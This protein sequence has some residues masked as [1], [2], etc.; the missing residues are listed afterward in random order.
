MAAKTFPAHTGLGSDNFA[1]RALERLSDESLQALATILNRAEQSGEWCKA[2]QLVLIVLLPKPDGDRRPIGLLPMP[3]RVWMRARINVAREWERA[4]H[5]HNVYAGPAMGAQRAAWQTSFQAE[6]SALSKL[7]YAQTNLDIV[8]AFE[9]VKHHLVV[10]AARKHGYNL[11]VL[12]LSLAAYRAPRAI[13][14]NGVYSR[15]IIATTG[16]TAGSGFATSELRVLLLDLVDDSYVM[17]R[18]IR[19]QC[20]YYVDDVTIEAFG[21]TG[22]VHLKSSAASTYVITYFQVK[23]ELEVSAKKSGL[24]TAKPTLAQKVIGM[25]S[26]G[27]LQKLKLGKVL[28]VVGSGGAKRCIEGQKTRLKTAAEKIDRVHTMRKAGVCTTHIVKATF[29]AIMTYDACCNGVADGMLR[30]M[31]TTTARGLAPPTRGKNSELVLYVADAAGGRADPAFEAHGQPIKFWALSWW[32]QWR[33]HAELE[34]AHEQAVAKLTSARGSIWRVV[35]GPATAVVATAW[36]IGWRFLNAVEVITESGRKL[37]FL[38][39]SPEAIV[40]AVYTSVRRWRLGRI[41]S[42]MPALRPKH[43]AHARPKTGDSTLPPRGY[44]VSCWV[45]PDWNDCPWIIGRLL[46]GRTCAVK[47]MPMW[48]RTCRASLTSTI[49]GGQWTQSRLF[50]TKKQWVSDN[51][52]RLCGAVEGTLGH[53]RNCTTTKPPAGWPEQPPEVLALV[54]KLPRPAQRM[55]LDRGLLIIRAAIPSSNPPEAIHWQKWFEDGSREG[56][57]TWYVDGSLLDGPRALTAAQGA[58][59]AAVGPRGELWAY[60]H[61]APPPWAR[62]IP[63]VEAWAFSV[64]LHNTMARRAVIT[65]CLGNVKILERGAELATDARR[66]MARLWGPI[67]QAMDGCADDGQLTWMPAHTSVADVGRRIRS[68]GIAITPV[69][70]RAN[71]LVDGLAKLAAEAR[72]VPE[73]ARKFIAQAEA[74]V[75]HSAAMIGVTCKAANNHKVT[76]V[77]AD[78]TSTTKVL[79]DAQPLLLVARAAAKKETRARRKAQVEEAAAAKAAKDE[80]AK[81]ARALARAKK[82]EAEEKALD[83]HRSKAAKMFDICKPDGYGPVQER[84][85]CPDEDF[86]NLDTTMKCARDDRD[87]HY[88]AGSACT[89]H[90]F[91]SDNSQQV[92]TRSQPAAGMAADLG[93]T[94]SEGRAEAHTPVASATKPA[95]PKREQKDVKLEGEELWRKARVAEATA[96]LPKTGASGN[97]AQAEGY[98]TPQQLNAVK[99]NQRRAKEKAQQTA[100]NRRNA[101][102]AEGPVAKASTKGKEGLQSTAGPPRLLDTV[103]EFWAR[104]RA[105]LEAAASS[106]AEG[107]TE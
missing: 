102:V 45:P 90:L 48:N 32:Q 15:I 21:I 82:K 19:V 24:V 29:P 86:W 12:R 17:F 28:G 52:C 67:F 75:E 41:L 95:K 73:Y 36:R 85:T 54:N 18:S 1:P 22:T 10:R 81:A 46:H 27:K 78:G 39:D 25:D 97:L 47:S 44:D 50:A 62:T 61:G 4:H 13:G 94:R 104:K 40:Q 79:R 34:H 71:A 107:R 51:K 42:A 80:E 98:R 96:S 26:T 58:G 43:S 91:E 100:E 63:A 11:L 20:L 38:K 57:A 37:N 35:T 53:R 99:Q 30:S 64:V 70:H 49:V 89:E 66:P 14:V 3:I 31:R 6:S 2:L 68:D 105:K 93:D 55:L 65:D 106:S 59:F 8:K 87:G 83:E 88:N 101:I 84:M 9:K 7:D 69:D 77:S 56:E 72:R 60:G 23:L 16:I 76:M 103:A 92:A 33:P 74:A 5:R